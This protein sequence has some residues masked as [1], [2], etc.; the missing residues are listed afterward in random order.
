M[1]KIVF[2]GFR[3]GHINGLYGVA[4][5]CPELEIIGG[6]EPDAETRERAGKQLN[7]NISGDG[8]AEMLKIADI[9]AIGGRYG[10]RGAAIIEALSAGKHVISDKPIC[11]SLQ[12]FEEIRRLSRER[13]LSV[14]C[15]LD[16]RYNASTQIAKP[17]FDRGELGEVRNVSFNGQHCLDYGRR[18]TWYFEEGMHGGTVN[19][20]AIHGV[21][22]IRYL[23]GLNF[24]RAD[25]V[26]AWNSY[27]EKEP[28]FKDSA[29]LMARLENGA[30]VMADVSYASPTAAFPI[31]SYWEFRFWCQWGM[32]EFNYSTPL[33]KVYRGGAEAVENIWGDADGKTWIDDLL[34][35]IKTGD[36][37]IT[38][39]ML[40]SA[41]QTL[42]LQEQAKD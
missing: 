35:E 12:E 22:L 31:P 38:E 28:H 34:Y 42:W 27:A 1:K 5:A 39:D 23:T 16:L 26:R 24:T 18:P 8:Y 14:I 20:I 40:E 3:H 33:V 7:A 17:I 30:G 25:A 4:K 36:R 9:V 11:T 21:D 19:Y 37:S 2:N 29:M 13:G 41:R 10:E 6:Y 15:M 32:L